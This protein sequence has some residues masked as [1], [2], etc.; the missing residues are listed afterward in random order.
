[1]GQVNTAVAETDTGIGGS[2]QD[3]TTRRVIRW[4]FDDPVSWSR[5]VQAAT[6]LGKDRVLLGSI[7][8]LTGR[9]AR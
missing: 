2:Q 8:P 6:I 1:M 4:I 7:R 9:R 5:P 3:F